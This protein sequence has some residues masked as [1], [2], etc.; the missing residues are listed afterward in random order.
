LLRKDIAGAFKRRLHVR[1]GIVDIGESEY[2]RHR[3]TIGENC[4]R[5]PPKP[6]LARDLGLRAALRF[7][8]QIDVFEFRL[9]GCG[10]DLR[11]Q[12]VG[13]LALFTDRAEDGLA[14]RVEFAQISKPL[15]QQSKLRV[16]QSSRHLFAVASHEWNRR[17]LVQKSDG[18]R[19]LR[20]FR[21]DLCRDDGG[22]ALYVG[23]HIVPGIGER[24]AKIGTIARECQGFFYR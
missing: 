20:G 3:C 4:F 5:Q 24:A 13:Q 14:T 12:F 22:D 21:I 10:G 11:F 6:M 7:K 15:R 23:S 1:H 18:R 16:V 19:R 2:R 17:A 9:G 8:G